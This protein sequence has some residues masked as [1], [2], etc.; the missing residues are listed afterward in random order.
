MNKLMCP[1]HPNRP[2]VLPTFGSGCEECEFGE[3]EFFT[4][5]QVAKL[6]NIHVN[7]LKRMPPEDLPFMRITTRGDR[8][9]LRKDIEAFIEKRIINKKTK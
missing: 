2:A 1:Y 7:T 5:Y 9:Y 4:A 6:F 3:P 8:R